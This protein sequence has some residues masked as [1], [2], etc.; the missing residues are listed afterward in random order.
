MKLLRRYVRTLLEQISRNYHTIDTDPYSYEDY[1]GIDTEVFPMS[2]GE[3]WFAQVTVD[4]D[5]DLSTPLR[6]FASEEDAQSFARK[7]A[8]EANR[9]RMSKNINTDTT[10][11]TDLIDPGSGYDID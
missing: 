4:F 3:Q 11:F 7:H 6:A 10:T 9:V 1:P 8:E 5:D 2:N